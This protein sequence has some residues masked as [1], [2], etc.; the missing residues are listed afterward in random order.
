MPEPQWTGAQQK[1][2]DHREG[3]LLVSAAAG[4]G[5]TAVLVERVV[6]MICREQQPVPADRL[7]IVT[8]TKAA[9]EELRGRIA[10]R[11]EKEILDRHGDVDLRR[12]RMLLRRA[13]IGTI[14][15]LCQQLVREHFAQLDLPSDIAIGD[16]ALMAQLSQNAM[17]E[18][19]EEMYEEQNFADFASLYGR[20]RSDRAAEEAVLALYEFT[21]TLAHPER[22]LDRY[23]AMYDD[24]L[25]LADTAWGKELFAYAQEAL[26]SAE[27]LAQRGIHL[28]AQT[29]G[30]E[31]YHEVLQQDLAAVQGLKTDVLAKKW[32]SAYSRAENYSFAA[33][34]AVRGC[35]EDVKFRIKSLR[36]ELREII[37][38]LKKYCF[39]CTEETYLQDLRTARPLVRALVQAV[40]LYGEK[41]LA[42]KL[43][44]RVLDFADFEQLA[45]RLLERQPERENAE[46]AGAAGEVNPGTSFAGRYDV[47]MVDEYQDTNELQDALYQSLANGRGSN[48]F[49]VGDVKQSI[50]RFRKADPGIFLAKKNGWAPYEAGEEPSVLALGHN[51]RSSRQVVHGVNFLFRRLMSEALG[52]VGYSDGEA[53]LCGKKDAPEGAFELCVARDAAGAGD[54]AYVAQ[55]IGDMVQA[56]VTIQGKDGERPCNPGDF[57]ILLRARTH[58]MAYLEEL[59]RRGI[60]AVCDLGEEVMETPE[61]L[62]L[63]AALMAI[64]NP[65]DDV[66]LAAAML[67]P[68]FRFSPDEMTGLRA[69]AGGGN[70]WGALVGSGAGKV[71][72][73]VAQVSFYRTLAGQMSAGRLCEELVQ[74]TGYLSAVAAMEDGEVRQD[75]LLRFIGWAKEVSAS[76]RG[77][78]AAFARLLAAGRG[79]AASAAKSIPGYVN[80]LTIH[81]SKGLEF[82]I[83]FLADTTLLFNVWDLSARVQ[84]HTG[85]GVG[86]WL[87]QGNTLFATLPALAIRRRRDVEA[88]SEE[89]RVLYVALTRAKER[90]IVTFA[91]KDPATFVTA[92]A[93]RACGEGPRAFL[94]AR[95]RSMGEWIVSAALCHPEAGLLRALGGDLPVQTVPAEGLLTI[96]VVDA[97][98]AAEDTT[99]T[100]VL[101]AQADP[102]FVTAVTAGFGAQLPR[103]ALRSVPA[104]MS[105]SALVK[106]E[107]PSVPKR[108]SFMYKSGLTAAEAGT[109]QHSFMQYA[110]FENARKDPAAEVRRLVADGFLDEAQ[111]GGIRLEGIRTFFSSALAAR[112]QGANRVL[113][114][115]DFITA[116]PAAKVKNGLPT[117]L[118][119]ETVLVQ[120]IADAVLVR[121]GVAEIVDYKT[122]RG[123]TGAELAARYG[124]QLRLYRGAIE[125]ALGVPVQKLTLW[126]FVLGEEVDVPL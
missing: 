34:K 66:A 101:T 14:D 64:D 26:E 40:K 61:V 113:R 16:E 5:K 112:M 2:I 58:M 76:G 42:A 54:A 38:E 24:E 45:L 84:M 15:A 43:A 4:S 104:K 7:L 118:A 78:L 93:A 8:F 50:Y 33:L 99:E 41:Y 51:F 49:Y 13:F 77:G 1:A 6:G 90:M 96:Q 105:V 18:T 74:R 86:L 22:H 31:F 32:D 29:P 47:V 125:K 75:N 37:V 110:D 21:R 30:A 82:P 10:A 119:G 80:I 100:F 123:Q 79:P 56:G 69:Q 114:E 9:A 53:L 89:M 27:E 107:T 92:Q 35:E 62:P 102:A 71:R 44:E 108:P 63:S 3:A 73:F 60:P 52:E 122:D 68:L 98:P 17:A 120:G 88:M 39:V 57:C 19:M 109:V 23:A 94:Q 28:A 70:L 91:H 25:P 55:R 126:S 111:A 116:I 59:N 103:A 87:R 81:K 72:A 48:L 117:E 85:L 11:L 20:A 97:P 106:G 67:G 121:D 36:E 115:Y 95:A 65:G 83:C 124:A 46:A 12:Q